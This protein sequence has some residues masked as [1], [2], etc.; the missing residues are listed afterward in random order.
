M[1]KSYSSLRFTMLTNLLFALGVA[2]AL[3][4]L[5]NVILDK[6]VN[7]RYLADARQEARIDAYAKDLQKY[8]DDNDLSVR[9]ASEISKWAKENKY[10]YIIVISYVMGQIYI[11]YIFL[12]LKK[13]SF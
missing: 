4:V 7:V 9:D 11:L 2:I 6:F 3:F 12:F 8:V 10:F 13:I 5:S 1:A